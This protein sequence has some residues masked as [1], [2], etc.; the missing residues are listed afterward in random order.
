MALL[1]AK[2]S[3]IPTKRR[4][5]FDV[6]YLFCPQQPVLAVN[7]PEPIC[8]QVR[9][10]KLQRN[11]KYLPSIQA[12]WTGSENVFGLLNGKTLIYKQKPI[13]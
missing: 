13:H 5:D 4:D 12:G 11:P 1:V 2:L 10:K 9:L 6:D 3:K 7:A 8:E